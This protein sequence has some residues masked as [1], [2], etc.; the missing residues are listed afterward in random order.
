METLQQIIV[1][2]VLQAAA[3]LVVYFVVSV[4]TLKKV[5]DALNVL[6]ELTQNSIIIVWTVE[7]L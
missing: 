5:K 6:K 3:A 1:N 4:L 7:S 2:T